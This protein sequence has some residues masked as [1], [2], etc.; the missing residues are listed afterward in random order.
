MYYP[1]LRSKQFELIALREL[2]PILPPDKFNP[3]IEPVRDNIRSLIK[4]II[5]LNENNITPLIVM[6]PEV[7]D[8]QSNSALLLEQLNTESENISFHPCINV[9]TENRY[10]EL[11]SYYL[12][13]NTPYVASFN[14]GIDQDLINSHTSAINTIVD[15]N[16]SPAILAL[17]NNLILQGDFFD[18]QQRNADYQRESVFSHLHTSNVSMPNVS[19]FSDFTLLPKAFTEGGGPAY[20]V[21]IHASYIDYS[22]FNEM[23]VRHY[24]SA[25]NRSPSNPAGKFSEALGLL[26][27]DATN[28]PSIFYRSTGMNE[29][30]TLHSTGHFPGLGTVKKLSIKHHIETICNYLEHHA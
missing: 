5:A 21:T 19:G 30:I 7:G 1:F 2:A 9:N 11:T 15:V 14:G 10:N 12:G 23:F 25:D 4:T 29:F 3:I 26:I 20:V 28:D 17:L 18:K 24:S 16:T 27:I 22:R 13:S 8:Y 6:N